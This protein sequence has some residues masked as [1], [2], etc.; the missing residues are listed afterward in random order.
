MNENWYSIVT[1][2]SNT[3]CVE[4]YDVGTLESLI[5]LRK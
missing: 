5:C 1:E 2:R 4:S 3:T